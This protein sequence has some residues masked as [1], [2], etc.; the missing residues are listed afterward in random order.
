[1]SFCQHSTELPCV[2]PAEEFWRECESLN[3]RVRACG[4][5]KEPADPAAKAPWVKGGPKL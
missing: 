1:M 2:V 4:S 3:A 5:D